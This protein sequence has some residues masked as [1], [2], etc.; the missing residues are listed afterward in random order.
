M[1]QLRE[2]FRALNHRDFRLYTAGQIVSLTGSWMQSVAQS[3]LIYRL[4][5][6]EWMM[7]TVV[8]ATHI[9]VLLLGPLG[10][11]AADRFPRQRVVL[12]TQTVALVQALLLAGLNLSGQ[13]TPNLVL[14]LAV[15]L[16]IANA[17]DIPGRQ[18][19]FIQMVG[20]QDLISAISLNSAIFNAS[21]VVGPS[22]AGIIVAGF[23]ETVCF[24]VNAASFLAMIGCVAAMRLPMAGAGAAEA[25]GGFREG[26]RYA[27]NHK[28]LRVLLGVCGLTGLCY[29]PILALA[30]FFAD[31]I[32]HQGSAGLGFLI[33]AMGV[34]AVIGVV[35]LARHTGISRLPGVSLESTLILAFS[36]LAFG[37][38]PWFGASIALMALIGFSVMRQNSCSNSLIQCTVP[39]HYRG[40]MMALF[41]MVVTGL[42][43]IGS[44]ASGALAEVFGARAVVLAA[45]VCCLAGAAALR[46]AMPG[47]SEWVKEQEEEACAA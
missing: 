7:G 44:L 14:V 3:W 13:I 6:S 17:F 39:D 37:C 33:G 45:G 28:Q 34:G 9:P 31:G 32:F 16:G 46:F 35:R 26:F 20:K 27:W 25:A 29:S 24:F 43:P 8:F 30:P 40:R 11:M 21:R 10:G 22:L 2:S 1:P 47:F 42:L 36:L 41:S 19:L 18:T 4:T 23:G 38:S 15:V 5:H 12:I